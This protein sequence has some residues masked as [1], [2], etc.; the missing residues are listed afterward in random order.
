M[1]PIDFELKAVNKWQNLMHSAEKRGLDFD[2]QVSD[3]KR[4]LRR[5]TCYYSGV[6][7]TDAVQG[8]REP[9][10]RTMERLDSS[11]G[12]VK[13]NVVACSHRMNHIKGDATKEELCLLVKKL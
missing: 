11:K 4:L 9:T 7:L 10:E 13:G 1:N 12:Y 3:V 6:V 8:K 5:K 2:L